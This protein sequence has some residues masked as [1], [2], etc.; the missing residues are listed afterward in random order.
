MSPQLV[1]ATKSLCV[2]RSRDKLLQQ[3]ARSRE[4]LWKSLSQQQSFVAATSRRNSV[5][6]DFVRLVVATKFCFGDRD[7]HKNWLVAATCCCNLSPGVFRPK[8]LCR[9]PFRWARSEMRLRLEQTVSYKSVNFVN[10]PSLI[11]LFTGMRDGSIKYSSANENKFPNSLPLFGFFDIF[12]YPEI[13]RPRHIFDGHWLNLLGVLN[14]VKSLVSC[15]TVKGY[16][17]VLLVAYYML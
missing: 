11:P 1:A 2:Y 8:D 6:F 7:F 4:F 15:R 10:P 14:F 5:W 9:I 16:S 3:F 13:R 12:L 17:S